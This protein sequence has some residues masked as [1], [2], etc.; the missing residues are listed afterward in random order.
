MNKIVTITV[1][2]LLQRYNPTEGGN[3]KGTLQNTVVDNSN[4]QGDKVSKRPCLG[5][6]L[7]VPAAPIAQSNL[8]SSET[9]ATSDKKIAFPTLIITSPTNTIE[10]SNSYDMGDS[11]SYRV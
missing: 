7:S 3:F 2:K 9:K 6:T 10:H 11:V 8:V 5:N 1:K 4:S